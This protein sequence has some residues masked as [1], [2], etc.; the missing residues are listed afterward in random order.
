MP[1]RLPTLGQKKHNQRVF[2]LKYTEKDRI[3][4]KKKQLLRR[5]K[6]Y[7][8]RQYDST[9]SDTSRVHRKINNNNNDNFVSHLL[10]KPSSSG[11]FPRRWIR[12]SLHRLHLIGG[13]GGGVSGK[14]GVLT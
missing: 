11:L 13:E 3:E 2:L 14:G 9:P 4:K 8:V 10:K 6:R 5:G 7:L 1:E 12:M